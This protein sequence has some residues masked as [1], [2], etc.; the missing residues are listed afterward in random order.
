MT[1][2]QLSEPVMHAVRSGHTI[3]AIKLLRAETG[4]GLKEAK[5]IVD[6]EIDAYRAANPHAAM[7]AESSPWGK[8]VIIALIVAAVYWF[9]TRGG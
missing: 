1:E 2:T 6:R 3:K 8:L 5:H 7:Q 9:F 4:L